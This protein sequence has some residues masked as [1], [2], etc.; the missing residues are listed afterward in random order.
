LLAAAALWFPPGLLVPLAVLL[1]RAIW[2]PHTKIT[3]KQSGMLEI[4]Y[5]MM[6]ACS[7][8]A[9]YAI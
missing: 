8:L 7:V 1:V 2:S 3:V 4:A 5:S 9:V 6:I